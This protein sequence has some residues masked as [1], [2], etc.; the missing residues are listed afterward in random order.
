VYFLTETGG[1]SSH[2][3]LQKKLMLQTKTKQK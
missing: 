2:N 1:N 3:E